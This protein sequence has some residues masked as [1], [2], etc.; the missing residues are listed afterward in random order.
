VP[1]EKTNIS[2]RER[3]IVQRVADMWGVSIEEAADRLRS[4]GMA[5]RFRKGV[6]RAP[7]KVYDI[8]RKP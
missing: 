1:E 4:E 6:R 5:Q 7:A 8:R 2:D 3:E